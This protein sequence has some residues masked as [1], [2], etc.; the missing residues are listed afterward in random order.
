MLDQCFA[1]GVQ[2]LAHGFGLFIGI[3]PFAQAV[4]GDLEDQ[5]GEGAGLGFGE[6][7]LEGEHDESLLLIKYVFNSCI[8]TDFAPKGAYCT[9]LLTNSLG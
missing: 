9:A 4:G 7:E 1:N 2:G 3:G 6:V 5:V 8:V